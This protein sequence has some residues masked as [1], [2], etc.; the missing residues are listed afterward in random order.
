MSHNV[1][2]QSF[3]VIY[4]QLLLFFDKSHYFIL[5]NPAVHFTGELIVIDPLII[6]SLRIGCGAG[7]GRV[8]A[9]VACVFYV[10]C[11]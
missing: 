5:C 4:H 3:S 2:P 6:M 8:H 10:C 9:Q 1:A 7:S 11:G